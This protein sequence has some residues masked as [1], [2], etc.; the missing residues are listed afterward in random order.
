MPKI[1]FL[2]PPML[3]DTVTL[4]S[5]IYEEL[6]MFVDWAQNTLTRDDEF[7]ATPLEVWAQAQILANNLS[8]VAKNAGVLRAWR[9]RAYR[10]SGLREAVYSK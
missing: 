5:A 7:A 9:A 6:Q 3:D 2:D 4:D 10:E 1:T 8:Y